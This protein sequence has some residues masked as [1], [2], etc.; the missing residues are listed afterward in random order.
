MRVIYGVGVVLGFQAKASLVSS[1]ELD[2]GLIGQHFHCP[3]ALGFIDASG[4]DEGLA[5]S[6][7]DVV[8]VVL[9]TAW[10]F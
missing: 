7:N 3:S 4:Q 2:A 1:V 8:I 9:A 5:V 10:F 6:V